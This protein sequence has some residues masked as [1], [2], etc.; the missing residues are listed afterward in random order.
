MCSG[1]STPL[2]R[3]A[4]FR[5]SRGRK[6]QLTR[7]MV[8]ARNIFERAAHQART[9]TA[10]LARQQTQSRIPGRRHVAMSTR[11]SSGK[12]SAALTWT[13]RGRVMILPGPTDSQTPN[14]LCVF[15]FPCPSTPVRRTSN[16]LATEPAACQRPGQPQGGGHNVRSRGSSDR[17][18]GI[19]L[20]YGSLLAKWQCACDLGSIR[21]SRT[22][23]GPP[24]PR[25]E[26]SSA[27]IRVGARGKIRPS[28][29][30]LANT[31]PV[32]YLSADDPPQSAAVFVTG[33]GRISAP[34]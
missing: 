3:P 10:E 8:P 27:A 13:S 26:M 33:L 14:A 19:R 30:R 12:P 4:W 2:R 9:V 29:A 28:R 21:P 18:Y 34:L 6:S 22:C 25:A 17:G 31:A 24:K 7:S 11:P 16:A 15:G 23:F 5:D 32:H 1:S 20:P